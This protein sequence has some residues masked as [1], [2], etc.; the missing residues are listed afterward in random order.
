MAARKAIDPWDMS[1][2]A[3]RN[4]FGVG[5]QSMDACYEAVVCVGETPSDPTLP[6]LIHC[7]SSPTC[8]DIRTP[9]VANPSIKLH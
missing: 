7:S 8:T 6:F 5:A 1:S 4:S 2:I 9:H 3:K